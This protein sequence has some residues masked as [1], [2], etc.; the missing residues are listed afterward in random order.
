M[1]SMATLNKLAQELRSLDGASYGALKKLTGDWDAEWFDLHIDKVQS[2]PYAPA[3][4]MH[5]VVP[6]VE[7][8][9]PAELI[10]THEQRV[11]V[12][13][14]IARDF[15]ERFY[16]ASR[17]FVFMRPGQEILQRSSVLITDDAVHVRFSFSFPA[18]GRRVK[19]NTAS[20]LLGEELPLLVEDSV[21]AEGLDEA[22][23]R[24]HVDCYTDFLLIQQSLAERNLV[25]FVADGAILPRSSGNDDTPLPQAHP[26]TAPEGQ[27]VSF[28]RPNGAEV[29]GMG[30]P[31][32]ITLIVGGG[33]H[34]KST[35]LRAIERGV[36]AHIPGDGRELVVCDASAISIRA[37][38]G[39]A[40]CGT[41]IS[42]FIQNLPGNIPTQAFST[43]N[44][45]GSTSQAANL[46][47]AV[48][49]GAQTLLIDEDTSATNFMI[50]DQRM[51]ELI[52]GDK[53]PITPFVDRVKDLWEQRGIS[54]VLV[55][56]GSGAFFEVA[57]TVIAMDSFEPSDVTERAREIA[58]AHR[59]DTA[60]EENT[61]PSSAALNGLGSARYPAADSLAIPDLRKP[62]RRRGLEQIQVG[63]DYIDLR[64]VSQLVDS[65]QT[66]AIAMSWQMIAE[67]LEAG[68]SLEA[69]AH[70]VVARLA[71]EG[72]DTLVGVDDPTGAGSY[73]VRGDLALPRPAEVLQAV[74]RWRGL[75]L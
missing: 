33:F 17:E 14:F 34:G 39:R 5:L 44:A 73:R 59:E 66:Q 2:D 50:R 24:E 46:A 37:E 53:E 31:A 56:G 19:G 30:I 57:D 1:V 4:R 29:T 27:R 25:A 74:S 7:T 13:D 54:T 20:R 15:S 72:L 55:M 38:D 60:T 18:A 52:A 51:R 69:A 48:E 68:A 42:A 71:S 6:H 10:A 62:P 26:F 47:E 11:A 64:Y 32:G 63:R 65:S 58:R 22:A 3:S 35:L 8:D 40:V 21:L 16:R 43:Q 36:Y 67:Q 23:L 61:A 12:A 41:N 9:I 45:S 28:P 70:D 75:T 49:V